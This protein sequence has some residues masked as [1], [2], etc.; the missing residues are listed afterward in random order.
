MRFTSI[1]VAT[2]IGAMSAT[3]AMALTVTNREAAD[4]KIKV[5]EQNETKEHN[6]AAGKTLEGVCSAGCV[7]QLQNGD[8][9]EFEG[10]EVVSIEDG[11][12]FLDEPTQGDAGD[13]PKPQ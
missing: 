12:M 10:T 7:V 4:H 1:V 6:V 3:S 5:I 8:E 9:Y 2:L 13:A 11:Y